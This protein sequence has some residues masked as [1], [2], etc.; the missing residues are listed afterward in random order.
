MGNLKDFAHWRRR[1]ENVRASG[2][3]RRGSLPT[4]FEVVVSCTIAAVLVAAWFGLRPTE[5]AS[6]AVAAATPASDLAGRASVIDGDTLEIRG[7]RVRLIGIDAPESRQSCQD[8][9]G[10]PWR[11]GQRAALALADK[12]GSAPVTCEGDELDRYG[13]LLAVCQARGE[14][15]GAWLV[16]EG[17]ALAYRRYSEVYIGQEDAA[18]A[19]RRGVWAGIFV[20]PWDWRAQDSAD[21]QAESQPQTLVPAPGDTRDAGSC[22]IKGNISSKGER[23]YHV[24]GGQWYDETKISQSKGERWFC[25]EAEARAAG[26]RRS[27]K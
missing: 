18:R 16:S 14:D 8:A 1:Q 19:A 21:Q 5:R 12:I 17:L 4:P 23:I 9:S 25:S 11:C 22:L 20:P 24:P 3:A 13:R 2:H 7:T 26:W 10:Q 6:T 27:K 15:L